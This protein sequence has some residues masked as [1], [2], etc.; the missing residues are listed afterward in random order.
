MMYGNPNIKFRLLVIRAERLNEPRILSDSENKFK[1]CFRRDTV[2]QI[3]SVV[4]YTIPLLG[5]C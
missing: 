2:L 1:N 5:D 3:G 4:N